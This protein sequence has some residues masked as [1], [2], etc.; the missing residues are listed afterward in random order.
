MPKDKNTSSFLKLKAY[1]PAVLCLLF[2]GE[3]DAGQSSTTAP[4]TALRNGRTILSAP[5]TS[6]TDE[7]LRRN[8]VALRPHRSLL[9]YFLI[10][11]RFRR[12][13]IKILCEPPKNVGYKA[14]S[15]SCPPFAMP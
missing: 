2:K 9:I 12:V 5:T 13:F 10:D 11:A 8:G 3:V 6:G 7:M 14:D 15:F 1:I 4:P